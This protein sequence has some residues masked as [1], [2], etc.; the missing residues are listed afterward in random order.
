MA[1]A[2]V[3][4]IASMS[5]VM[6]QPARRSRHV[7]SMSSASVSVRKPPTAATAARRQAPMAPGTTVT[8]LSSALAR[9]SRFWLAMYSMD[10]Q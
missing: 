10:C 1:G 9:R 6:R 2:S 4:A 7:S 3:W 5:A 8:P